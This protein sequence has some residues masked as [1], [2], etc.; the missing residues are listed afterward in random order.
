MTI[1][2]FARGATIALGLG[3]LAGCSSVQ[4]D[5]NTTTEAEF[6]TVFASADALAFAG[7]P[8][9]GTATY[10]GEMQIDTM[11][12]STKT[13]SIRGG[14]VMDVSFAA[15]EPFT[16]HAG[17]FAGTVNGQRVTY[18]GTLSS[19]DAPGLLPINSIYN[20]GI[21]TARTSSM[22]VTIGGTLRNDDTGVR[23]R[24]RAGTRLVGDF[25]GVNARVISGD[26]QMVINPSRGTS[27]IT[28][29]DT[30]A[31]VTGE[32]YAISN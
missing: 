6:D 24:M 4:F 11:A 3:I 15:T 7:A 21:G 22:W 2:F 25:R 9:F 26:A 5:T 18:S 13:G 23:N 31:T 19:D 29:T 12:G 10:E 27:A 17:G 16:A 32:F 14:L 30:E 28:G 8:L 1:C 20:T